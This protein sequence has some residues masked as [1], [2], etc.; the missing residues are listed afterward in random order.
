MAIGNPF[1][2]GHTVTVG[3]I[4]ALGRP[5]GGVTGR[6]A[7]DAADRRRH[8]PG[9]SGGPLLNVRGEVVGINTAIYTDAQR[10]A[11]I[12]I[13]FATP[14]NS[15][16]DLP[17]AAQ[18]QS[19]ARRDRRASAPDPITKDDAQAL[20]LPKEGAARCSQRQAGRAGA[21][22]RAAAG[23]RHRRVQ[24]PSGA[25][26]DALVDD[27]RRHQARHDRAADGLPRQESAQTVNITIEELDLDAEQGPARGAARRTTSRPRPDSAWTSARSRRTSRASSSCRATAAAR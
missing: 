7:D 24:R 5:F 23:R 20:G 6:R 14:I 3:V 19:H 13:G 8:Q 2:L 1:G 21:R 12:G 16:R 9:N 11:N 26:S 10:A 22:R 25:D 18:R 27:G 15:I 17:A 4:S